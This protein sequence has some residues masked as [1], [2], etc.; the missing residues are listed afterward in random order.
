MSSSPTFEERLA[1]HDKIVSALRGKLGQQQRELAAGTGQVLKFSVDGT[2][3][4]KGRPR[5]GLGR[6]YTPAKT[7][8]WE[9]AIAYAARRAVRESSLWPTRRD[10]PV[11]V[12]VD[13]VFPI[14]KSW[15]A[16]RRLEAKDEPHIVR[17]D[18]DNV[19]KS[20]LDGINKVVVA[21][22][23]QVVNI[24]AIKRY[25]TLPGVHVRVYALINE[26]DY[27]GHQ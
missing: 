5:F 6:V 8:V 19:V 27:G 12:D 23:A 16:K 2:P 3:E 25:G 26:S 22:D 18:L 13:A 15:P 14:P 7:K 11:A 20:V 1:E 10:G 17:P 24:S 4:G 21:D 9:Q